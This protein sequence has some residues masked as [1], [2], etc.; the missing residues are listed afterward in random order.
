MTRHWWLHVRRGWYSSLNT[1]R[2]DYVAFNPQPV[3]SIMVS[4]RHYLLGL[5]V[6]TWGVR[7]MLIWWHICWHIERTPPPE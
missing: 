4:F 5:R 6:E 7:I 3:I 1:I 2:A